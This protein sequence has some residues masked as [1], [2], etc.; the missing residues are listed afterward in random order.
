M[1]PPSANLN[2]LFEPSS[3]QP[4]MTMEVVG[5]AAN[6]IAIVDLS[7]KVATTIHQFPITEAVLPA[8]LHQILLDE[9]STASINSACQTVASITAGKLD[10]LV[11]DIG[12]STH[13]PA[14]DLDV[15][16]EVTEMFN[17]NVLAV[18]RMV[19][20]FSSLLISA[21]G[22]IVNIGSIV[23]IIPLP[24]STAYNA[25]KAALLAYGDGLRMEL[26]PFR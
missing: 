13:L 14:L 11:N 15:D 21:K 16:G 9:T 1:N 26:A 4:L 2:L 22:C 18:M 19:K 25:T 7:A 20:E 12:F 10:M 23:P 6:V 3:C 17:V 24:F 8:G 5:A